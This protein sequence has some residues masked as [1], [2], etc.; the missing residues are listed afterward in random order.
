[1]LEGGTWAAGRQLAAARRGGAPPLA[2]D[3]GG[4]VF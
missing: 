1:M 3:S 2:V 4:T